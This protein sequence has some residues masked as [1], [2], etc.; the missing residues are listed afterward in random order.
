MDP[1]IPAE[2]MASKNVHIVTHTG[3][4]TVP[5]DPTDSIS[6]GISDAALE[7]SDKYGRNIRQGNNFRL[8]GYG[9]S[10]RAPGQ[11]SGAAAICSL[12]FV[13]PNRHLVKAWNNSFTQWRKQKQIEARVGKSVRYDDFELAL[14]SG[15]VNGRTSHIY[16]NP[17]DAAD[18]DQH[19]LGLAGDSDDSAD[20]TSI[21][22]VYT[23]RF[24]PPVASTS[25]YGTT[26]KSAK[27][28]SEY[29][30]I[31]SDIYTTLVCNATASG[32]VDNTAL[33]NMLFGGI[34]LGDI[35]WLPAD[36]HI[37]VMCGL[38]DW[39]I[40]AFPEDT[41]GQIADSLTYQLTLVY[42]GWSPLADSAKKGGKK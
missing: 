5:N 14:N 8:I 7:L 1:I 27:F 31:N 9:L 2:P 41:I 6:S 21:T 35:Q 29:I 3:T 20:Y 16:D 11:D 25:H 23:S 36:N 33:P 10:I 37:N 12:T 22:D 30:D 18:G 26:V 17:F 40:R 13:E 4:F 38:V 28:G 24:K 32:N 34:A 15:H 39:Q 42:E 19:N